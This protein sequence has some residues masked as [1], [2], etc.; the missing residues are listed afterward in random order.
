LITARP[1]SLFRRADRWVRRHQGLAL[2]STAGIAVLVVLVWL[3]GLPRQSIWGTQGGAPA[4]YAVTLPLALVVLAAFAVA[5]RRRWRATLLVCL[6]A[7]AIPA[8]AGWLLR[9]GPRPLLAGLAHGLLLGALARLA[10]WGLNREKAAAFLGAL[11]GAYGGILLADGYSPHQFGFALADFGLTTGTNIALYSL[12][13]E[14]C[15]A[16]VGALAVSL[17]AGNPGAGKA[18]RADRAA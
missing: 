16:F 15:G 18:G 4:F 13:A 8:A 10:A 2:T 17:L 12:Y 14:V 11:L 9:A 1:P 5:S 7:L 3:F 6:P